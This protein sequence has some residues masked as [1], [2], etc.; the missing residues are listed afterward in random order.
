MGKHKVTNVGL[1]TEQGSVFTQ[2]G[3]VM[4]RGAMD[5][6]QRIPINPSPLSCIHLGEK[7]TECFAAT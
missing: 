3:G 1:V 5:K 6:T 2:V 4:I 7:S